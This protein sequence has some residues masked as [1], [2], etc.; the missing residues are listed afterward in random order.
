MKKIFYILIAC[1]NLFVAV[2]QDTPDFEMPFYFE[3][4]LGNRDTLILGYDPTAISQA[5]NTNFGEVAI[6]TPF[7][8]VFEVRAMHFDDYQNRTS[9]KI[10]ASQEFSS[11]G[12]GVFEI[13]YILINIQNLPLRVSW[14][15]ELLSQSLCRSGSFIVNNMHCLLNDCDLNVMDQYG[16]EYFCLAQQGTFEEDFDCL[17]CPIFYIDYVEDD[18]DI[19]SVYGLHLIFNSYN[20]SSVG[21]VPISQY[22]SELKPYPNPSNETI[23]LDTATPN[24]ILSVV[25]TDI[26]GKELPCPVIPSSKGIAIA[27]ERLP[28]GVYI[29]STQT[30]QSIQTFKFVK[31]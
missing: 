23:Y 4:A 12:C 31:W 22:A 1:V 28:L 24:D 9:K 16:Y 14:D 6:T 20:C 29:G 15:P 17:G 13:I 26:H 3:D 8:P 11:S 30:Q 27:I 10:I 7:D 18:I 25:L 5:L 19:A 2:A 21:I